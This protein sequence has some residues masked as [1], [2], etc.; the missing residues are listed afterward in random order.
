MT[1]EPVAGEGP[2]PR[3]A[4]P[5]QVRDRL[6]E[7]ERSRFLAEYEAALDEARRTL[8]L[9]PVHASVEHYR[10]IAIL[11]MDPDRF[12]AAVRRWAEIVTEAPIPDDEPFEVTRRKAG[13]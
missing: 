3:G 11:W 12:R 6:P 13:I 1:A 10:A 8:D 2:L 7:P 4:S 9:A 5:A